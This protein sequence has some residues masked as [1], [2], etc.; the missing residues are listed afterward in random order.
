MESTWSTQRLGS[1]SLIPLTFLAPLLHRC[2]R[3]RFRWFI[4]FSASLN[5]ISS[6]GRHLTP[7]L[8]TLRWCRTISTRLFC[9]AVVDVPSRIRA[10]YEFFAVWATL[11]ER[12][13]NTRGRRRWWTQRLWTL[14]LWTLR[15][16]R[17]IST[18]LSCFA[19][20]DMPGRIRAILHLIAVGT[21][22]EEMSWV[23]CLYMMEDIGKWSEIHKR[24]EISVRYLRCLFWQS[25]HSSPVCSLKVHSANLFWC[26]TCQ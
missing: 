11:R 3:L 8:Q 7:T 4:R 21:T 12:F 5:N 23:R 15:W 19:V 24:W 6:F 25:L 1:A 17:T 20:V 18:R 10:I 22:P 9:F 26:Q 2:I 13:K 16:C 14:R